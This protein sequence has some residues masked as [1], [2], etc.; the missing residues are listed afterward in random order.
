MR[1]I[2]IAGML[3]AAALIGGGCASGGPGAP[4]PGGPAHPARGHVVRHVPGAD[5]PT[6]DHDA[7]RTGVGPP[8]TGISAHSLHRLGLR[9]VHIDGTV[10]AAAI[11]LHGV[12][13]RGRVRDVIY[14]TTTYGHTIA[15]DPGT[16]TRLWEYTP[17]DIRS[18]QGSSQ[19]TTTTPVADPDR[20][21]IYAATPDG[22]VHKLSAA[23]GHEVRSGGWPVRVT[24]DATHEKMD[25]PLN[26]SGSSV[27]TVTGGYIGDAPVYQGHL[28]LI[29]R[30]S[31]RITR[32]FN[33]LCSNRTTLID[34]PSACPHSDSAIW[35][36]AGAVVEP[37]SGRILIATGNGADGDHA[38]FNGHTNWADSVLELSPSARL[39]HNWTPR[40]QQSLNDSDTDVGSTA[41]ALVTVGG[42]HLAVQGGKD[43]RL[44]LLDLDRLDG[45]GGPAGPR[46]GGELQTLPSPGGAQVFTAPAVWR[47]LVFVADDS[48]TT[49]FAVRGGA[50]PHLSV[51]WQSSTGGTS[52]VLAGGLLYVYDEQGGGLD[53]YAPASG[54][55]LATLRAGGGHWNSPIVA[56]GRI[57]LP[58]GSYHDHAASGEIYI[59]HLAGR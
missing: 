37:G 26:L 9:I 59:W 36:R 34:P 49:A 32:V 57:V 8:R 54:R 10:D 28:V 5:W 56:G 2:H 25:S 19:V 40:D 38:G 24:F 4:V 30:A 58:V 39:L 20:R 7:A 17:R 33:T 53:V 1:R 47:T 50:R 44:R 42:R 18:Y 43:G 31:G 29:D 48:G 52:P 15:I 45:T 55:R 6:F 27:I 46:T 16:G 11:E 35:A 14:V 21:Y 23:N 41:P 13:T 3:A 51:A 12:R 22:F